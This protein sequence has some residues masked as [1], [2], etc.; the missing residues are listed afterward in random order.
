MAL[1]VVLAA[2]SLLLS[3]CQ[4][5][6]PDLSD[7]TREAPAPPGLEYECYPGFPFDP[8]DLSLADGSETGT[9]PK[10]TALERVLTY[11]DT[12]TFPHSGWLE[13]PATFSPESFG[14]VARSGDNFY[15]IR[16]SRRAGKWEPSGWGACQPR[17]AVVEANVLQWALRRGARPSPGD[18][19][20]EV[21]L[22]EVEC[23]G[24]RDPRPH[25]LEPEVIYEEERILIVITAA[26]EPGGAYE[27]PG[28]PVV[29]HVIDLDEPTGGRTLWDAGFYPPRHA[30]RQ[31]RT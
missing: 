6:N 3:A 2:A 25:L 9:D 19:R 29:N 10:W 7:E 15:E 8:R 4:T 12:E 30:T 24:G 11:S 5:T 27:C 31:L 1:V 13:V 26:I 22:H 20:L 23:V 17:V 14:F 16:M 21:V 18:Q 28:N